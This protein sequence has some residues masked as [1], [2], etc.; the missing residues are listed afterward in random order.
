MGLVIVPL[1]T[2]VV[3]THVLGP[4]SRG[5]QVADRPLALLGDFYRGLAHG[6]VVFWIVAVGPAVLVYVVR[7]LVAL[8]RR[9]PGTPDET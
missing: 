1:L 7:L 2:W 9:Q 3:G 8:A 4:Y 5:T 6:Y